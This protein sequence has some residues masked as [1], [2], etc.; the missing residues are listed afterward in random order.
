MKIESNLTQRRHKMGHFAGWGWVGDWVGGFNA[1]LKVLYHQKNAL[2][3]R[4]IF[5]N[6]LF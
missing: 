1:G 4:G 5:N 2:L 6:A 3:W